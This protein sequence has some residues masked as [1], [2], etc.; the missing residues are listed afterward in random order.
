MRS[1]L[2]TR[3]LLSRDFCLMALR[4]V[5]SRRGADSSREARYASLGKALRSVPNSYRMT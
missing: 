4:P 3:F 1:A 5:M 2:A